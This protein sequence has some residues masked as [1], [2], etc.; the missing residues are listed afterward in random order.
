MEF[1]TCGVC[2]PTYIIEGITETAFALYPLRLSGFW[3]DQH[4]LS[5]DP[6]A[7]THAFKS[8]LFDLYSIVR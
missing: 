3:F 1:S 4:H 6:R 5:G 2:P 7:S 8:I